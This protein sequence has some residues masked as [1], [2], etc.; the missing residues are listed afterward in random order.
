MNFVK[1]FLAGLLAVIVGTFL[2]F[3]LLDFHSAGHRRVDGKKRCGASRVDPE[4]RLLRGADRRSRRPIR[5]PVI[6]LMTLQTHAAAV[7]SSRRSAPSRPRGAD[8]RIKGI[9]LRM[10]GAGRRHRF[11]APGGAARGAPRVQAERQIHRRLQRNLFP[12]AAITSPRSPTR[13]T[14]SP[15][16]C[17]EWAGAGFDEPDVLQG[18]AGQARPQA[19]RC[20]APRPAST[21]APSSLISIDKMSDRQPRADAGSSSAR[22]GASS[23]GA[24]CRGARHRLREDAARNRRQTCRWRFPTRRSKTG[25]VDSL[26]YEDQM[27]DVFRRTRA[28]PTTTTSSR[29]ATTPRRWAP[30]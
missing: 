29:W 13:S 28:S 2:V 21:R 12:G 18:A 10:N 22:C 9:Y 17:M 20:S 19:P 3:F 11:G 23:P 6:D 24:V 26:L 16:A 27:E 1:T 25:F 15:R 7:R 4:N 8:D 14:C 30:T 5:W